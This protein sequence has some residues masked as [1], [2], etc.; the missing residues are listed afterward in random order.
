MT[1]RNKVNRMNSLH[2]SKQLAHGARDT[3]DDLPLLPAPKLL[4][5]LLA[6]FIILGEGWEALPE[7]LREE[8]AQSSTT[9]ELL[10]NLVHH[11]LMTDYQAARVEA[12]T[13]F[14][15]VL[16]NYRVLDRLGAGAMGVVF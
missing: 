2:N 14:G 8:L 13:T 11:C 3:I 12:G 10:A 9:D 16:G 15:L 1:I 5:E 4:R 6:S 7:R